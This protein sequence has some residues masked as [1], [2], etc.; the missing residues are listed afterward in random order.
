MVLVVFD[1]RTAIFMSSATLWLLS[2]S[3]ACIS[4]PHFVRVSSNVFVANFVAKILVRLPTAL[5]RVDV[6]YMSHNNLQISKPFILILL[7]RSALPSPAHSVVK[8]FCNIE[9]ITA[10]V[11]SVYSM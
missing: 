7:R 9:A 10:N 4:S 1:I 6:L 8:T 11:A 2:R 3:Y 5:W